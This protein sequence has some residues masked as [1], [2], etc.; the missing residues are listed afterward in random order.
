M[1]QDSAAAMLASD[2]IVNRMLGSDELRIRLDRDDTLMP[3]RHIEQMT[4]YYKG[5]RVWGGD[6]ARQR[7]AT[8]AVSVFGSVYQGIDLDVTPAIGRDA[9]AAMLQGL[10]DALLVPDREPELVV[11]PEDGGTFR[12]VWVAQVLTSRERRPLLHRCEQRSGD[13][14]LRDAAAPGRQRRARPRHRRARRRQEGQR[15]A[16]WPAPS[17]PRIRSGRPR[18]SPS[19]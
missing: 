1:A 17:S 19:T 7:K 15:D 2:R 14:A 6:V 5:A 8:A 4:Q 13:P 16:G 18:S 11:L 3:G 12:L 10:G 9:A